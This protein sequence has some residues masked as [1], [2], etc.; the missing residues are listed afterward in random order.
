[1]REL[2]HLNM[3]QVNRRSVSWTIVA[4]PN[5]GWAET[6]FGEPDVDRLWDAVARATRLHEEDPV[7]AWQE[8]ISRLAQRVDAMNSHGFDL[9]HY[10][11]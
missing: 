9:L 2:A 10:E 8:H 6:V 11:G 1:M 5:E 4:C 7:A 3:G